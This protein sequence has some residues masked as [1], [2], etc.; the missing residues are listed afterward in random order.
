MSE[1]HDLR[2]TTRLAARP[3]PKVRDAWR[4]VR[5]AFRL[6]WEAHHVSHAADGRV[7]D[8]RR[9]LPLAQATSPN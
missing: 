8:H 5:R 3:P 6:V 9:L 1:P 4:N 7:D 2:A